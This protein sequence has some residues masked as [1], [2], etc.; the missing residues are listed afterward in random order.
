MRTKTFAPGFP[1]FII[2]FIAQFL[3]ESLIK[4][5]VIIR[6]CLFYCILIN[7]CRILF[8]LISPLRGLPKFFK[9]PWHLCIVSFSSGHLIQ[10]TT[11]V[12]EYQFLR[13][14]YIWKQPWVNSI[15]YHCNISLVEQ[16]GQQ[17]N[18]HDTTMY[19]WEYLWQLITRIQY[20]CSN[21]H[22]QYTNSVY[23]IVYSYAKS[24]MTQSTGKCYKP[25]CCRWSVFC[26]QRQ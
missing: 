13:W 19:Q 6:C 21:Q 9:Y 2:V 14:G 1:K 25:L 15:L 17:H 11:N 5:I 12:F 20:S 22:H 24:I 18:Q 10:V 7:L 3:L 8:A 4:Q 26:R 16:H 23:I